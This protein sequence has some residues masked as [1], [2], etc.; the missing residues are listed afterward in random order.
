MRYPEQF[1][2]PFRKELTDLGFEELRAPEDVDA[3]VANTPGT[4]LLVVNSICGC[5]AGK[6]RPGLALALRSGKRPDKLTAVFAGFDLEATER[7]RQHMAPNPPS[8][9]SMALF[10]EGKLV[11]MLH[12]S[13]I[14]NRDA[15][16]ISE[17]LRRAFDALC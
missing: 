8:S 5:A 7:A 3:A 9:P 4:L 15:L 6:A 14:E 2:A 13:Q 11:F 17:D 16:A 1:V 10:R 12:R